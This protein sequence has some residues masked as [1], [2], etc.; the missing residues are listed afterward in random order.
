RAMSA[1]AVITIGITAIAITAIAATAIT[2]RV[3]ATRRPIPITRPMATAITGLASASVAP[4]SASGSS[5][6]D[7]EHHPEKLFR[8]FGEDDASN[9]I[10]PKL[11]RHFVQYDAS[12]KVA[13]RLRTTL[14]RP[15]N[16]TRVRR[17]LSP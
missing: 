5:K 4:A 7:A 6:A 12:E 1:I 3:T 16:G 9:S 11:Y 15:P 17:A 14:S 2:R 10:N 8:P 13:L